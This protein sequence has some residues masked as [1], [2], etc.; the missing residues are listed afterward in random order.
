MMGA[1]ALRSRAG[2]SGGALRRPALRRQGCPGRSRASMEE[3]SSPQRRH[4]DE[5]YD[6]GGTAAGTSI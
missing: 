2:G 5:L 1:L 4:R 3:R 6:R